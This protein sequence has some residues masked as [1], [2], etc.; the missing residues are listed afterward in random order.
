MNDGF[1]VIA[2]SVAMQ[3]HR[4]RQVSPRSVEAGGILLGS[5]RGRHLDVTMATTPKMAD[6]QSRI[7]FH[8][9]S[10]FHQI[11]AIRAWRRLGRTVDYLGEWHTHPERVPAPSDIDRSEWCK[12]ARS[13]A[14]ELVFVILGVE[15]I[16]VEVALRGRVHRVTEICE[17]GPIA[18]R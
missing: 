3:L 18:P 7:G 6:R 5:R 8:R 1:I 4:F 11:F 2:A 15:G 17:V 12:L 10:A 13:R 9:L 16:W 14:N